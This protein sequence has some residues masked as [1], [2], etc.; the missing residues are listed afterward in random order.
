[1]YGYF[2]DLQK[3]LKFDKIKIDNNV[4]RLHYKITVMVFVCCGILI[5]SGQYIGDPI[6]CIADGVPGGL[7]DTYC[8]I[9]STFSIPSRYVLLELQRQRK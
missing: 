4:F 6:D 5:S 9:H 3:Y 1:M 2:D 8:W 7:M